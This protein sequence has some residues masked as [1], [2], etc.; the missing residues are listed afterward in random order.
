MQKDLKDWYEANGQRVC[1]LSRDLWEHSEASLQEHHAAKAV[2]AFLKQEG[3]TVKTFQAENRGGE[4]NAVEARW[5]SGKPVI[6]FMGELDALPGLGQECVS[7]YAP[8]PGPGHGCGHNLMGAG[9]AG[10]ASALRYAMEREGL[11]GTVVYLGCP[12]EETL[13]GKVYL[14]RDGYFD[15]LDL[16]LTWHPG[17]QKLGFGDNEM[18]AMTSIVYHFQGKTAHGATPWEGRSA[19]DAAELMSVGSQYLRE[20]MPA[21]CRI[22]HVYLE[23]GEQPNIVPER[24][25]IYFYI[26][27]RDDYNEELVRRVNLLAK[28]AAL[29]TE[30]TVETEMRT[31]CHGYTY[32]MTLSRYCWEAAKKIDPLTYSPEDYAFAGEIYQA[33]TGKEPPTDP[34]E[35][36]PTGIREPG[37]EIEF[38][39]G[40]TDAG[41]PAYI[42]PTAHIYGCGDI[43]GLP[44]HHWNVVATAGMDVGRR[45]MLYGGKI[46]A[47]CGYDALTQPELI[48]N[49]WKDFHEKFG[50]GKPY[51]CRLKEGREPL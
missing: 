32:N 33:V 30:T 24:A 25:A 38:S 10:C 37:G 27:S 45:A 23:A 14:A 17:P 42:V 48:E 5:G 9:M 50:A 3:F 8:I 31:A 36:L 21:D 18:N 4:P 11:P 2:A 29:M 51:V 13:Q 7:H 15:D 47:Q 28:G 16:C 6:G 1:A 26:R 20:H 43:H 39:A 22:H 34:E 49:C 44:G 19:L 35:L 40:T 41:E 12:A 46:L